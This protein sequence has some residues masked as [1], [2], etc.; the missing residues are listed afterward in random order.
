MA[1]DRRWLLIWRSGGCR[2]TYTVCAFRQ[3]DEP[4]GD[5]A[6]TSGTDDKAL[7]ADGAGVNGG[8]Q[9]AAPRL[10]ETML[11]AEYDT[12]HRIKRTQ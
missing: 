10:R 4:S 8:S 1:V 7:D 12:E 5:E 9:R 6:I 2:R 3:G 11:L